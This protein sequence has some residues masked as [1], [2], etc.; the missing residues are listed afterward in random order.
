MI[1][2]SLNVKLITIKSKVYEDFVD[3][4]IKKG[5][6]PSVKARFCTEELKVKPMIDYILK[7]KSHLLIVQGIRAD[8]SASR[9]RMLQE[10]SFFKYYFEPYRNNSMIIEELKSKKGKLT[11]K[12]HERLIKAKERLEEGKEDHKFHTYRKKE[13]IEWCKKYSDDILRPIFNWSGQQTISYCLDRG[14]PLNPLYYKGAKRVGCWPC[15]MCT[16]TEAKNIL[17]K[18][19]EA[20]GKI[21]DLEVKS[22]GTFFGPDYVPERYRRQTD[23]K[24]NKYCNIDDVLMYI[25][26]LNATG[27]LFEEIDKEYEIERRC[28]SA[29]NICE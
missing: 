14:L 29:Y 18:D 17:L 1:A 6:P 25:K 28:M 11:E 19:P 10:C 13:V 7:Q 9:S 8:E 20:V 16:K 21:R 2:E 12:Q 15:I 27:D 22:G 3:M 5:R 23:S 4:S 26:D 24:G